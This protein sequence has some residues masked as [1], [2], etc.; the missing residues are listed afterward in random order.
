[1]DPAELVEVAVLLWACRLIAAWAAEKEE[2]GGPREALQR[3]EL[4]V[5]HSPARLKEGQHDAR[6]D[7]RLQGSLL[8]WNL[9]QG[10]SL[11]LDAVRLRLYSYHSRLRSLICPHRFQQ[12]RPAQEPV[13]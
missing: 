12:W 8:H 3:W 4:E 11:H 2:V 6:M 9:G 7:H 10:L 5:E 1:M 13:T